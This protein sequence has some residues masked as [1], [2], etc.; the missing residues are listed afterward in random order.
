MERYFAWTLKDIVINTS[1]GKVSNFP[2]SEKNTK[3]SAER[4][5]SNLSFK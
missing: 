4:K 3:K 1:Q 2:F 5:V